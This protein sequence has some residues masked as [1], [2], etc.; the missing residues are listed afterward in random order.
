[1]SEGHPA[2]RAAPNT[3]PK[4]TRTPAKG[5][6]VVSDAVLIG[7]LTLAVMCG[8]VEWARQPEAR[9]GSGAWLAG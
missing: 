2:Q 6:H 7:N 3:T 9:P 4:T 1:L 5:A 8:L